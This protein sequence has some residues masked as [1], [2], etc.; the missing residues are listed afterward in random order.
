M[1]SRDSSLLLRFALPI[2]VL[3]ALL[4][5]PFGFQLGGL[6]EEWDVLGLF[7]HFGAFFVVGPSTPLAAHYLRPLTV[8]PHAIAYVLGPDSFASW[9]ILLISSLCVK[10][11]ASALLGSRLT[12]SVAMSSL[13]GLLVLLW[14]ADTMQLSFRSLHIDWALALILLASVWAL[15]AGETKLRWVRIALSTGSAVAL[16]TSILM[17]E[18]A[19]FLIPL[20]M[21][22]IFVKHGMRGSVRTL[23]Q[24]NA[25]ILAWVAV[26]IAYG[27]YVVIM[28]RLNP[29]SYQETVTGSNAIALVVHE[30]LP[31]LFTIGMTRS[32]V[33][34]W[35]DAWRITATEFHSYVYLLIAVV[36]LLATLAFGAIGQH[37]TVTDHKEPIMGARMAIAGLVLMALGFAPYLTSGAHLAIT[38]RTYLFASPGAALVALS[39]LLSL[40]TLARGAV[41]W[42]LASL[43]LL[44][45]LA[46]QL[47]QFDHYA[48]LSRDQ[49]TALRNIVENFDARAAQ[50]K[51][52]LLLDGSARFTHTWFLRDNLAWALSYLYALPI[53]K[54]EICTMPGGEW[55][56]LDAYRRSGR[57]LDR[58]GSW[59]LVPPAPVEGPGTTI[60]AP[61][62]ERLIS[63]SNV[64]E[65]ELDEGGRAVQSSQLMSYRA[66]LLT[67]DTSAARRYR[68][69]LVNNSKPSALERSIFRRYRDPW[70][71]HWDFGK[72]W[73]LEKPIRGTGWLEAE[74]TGDWLSH[75]ASSWKY[76]VDSRLLFELEPKPVDYDLLVRFEVILTPAIKSSIRAR[77]NGMPLEPVW[78]TGEESFVAKVPRDALRSGTNTLHIESALERDNFDLSTKMRG[79]DLHPSQ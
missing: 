25:P 40:R 38:Q 26:T 20:P 61:A 11:F 68:Q 17:Y 42:L 65:L 13:F 32:F 74:W 33:G 43:L 27:S 47:Y 56:R 52:L 29:P 23:K 55:Q 22:V 5:L 14:P 45:G 75:H 71:Y 58:E 36:A 48:S 51:T 77:L 69:I 54:V 30:Q 18:V 57:C 64:V 79:F 34:G 2:A 4:W 53:S 50:G 70:E 8:F 10:G 41:T 21:I 7:T 72:W 44:L 78:Q 62:E 46:A 67:G 24:H 15:K 63:K 35:I 16:V 3:V 1:T 12:K 39:C 31:K 73:S 76:L 6:L 28:S 9:N 60:Q 19:A 37:R 49:R 59:A 66:G